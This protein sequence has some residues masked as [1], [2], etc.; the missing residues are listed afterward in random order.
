MGSG[1]M[2]GRQLSG[3][4]A[5]GLGLRSGGGHH[6]QALEF[7]AAS[8]IRDLAG[9]TLSGTAAPAVAAAGAGRRGPWARFTRMP[10][11]LLAVLAAQSALSLRLAWSNTAFEDEALYLWTGHLEITHLLYHVPIPQA[12]VY[13]SG[14]PVIY[15][16]AGSIADSYGGLAAARALS[17]MFML[18][19]TTL[20]YLTTSRLFGRRAAQPPRRFSRHSARCRLLAHTRPTTQWPFCCW[21]SQ[22]GSPSA[23]AARPV[24]SCCWPRRWRWLWR[25]RPSTR[26][27]CGTR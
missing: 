27:R 15:P 6:E 1:A 3:R 24:S 23:P 13:L 18:A 22:R 4:L 9:V 10:W 8:A 21:H 14:S 16:I 20:L 11:P 2:G 19:T 7:G 25:T 12:Q 5:H 17:L 26:A